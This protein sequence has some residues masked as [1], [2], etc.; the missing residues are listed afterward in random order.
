MTTFASPANSFIQFRSVDD[1]T[2]LTTCSD[3]MP[4]CL[5]V[6]FNTDLMFQLTMEL[7]E[8]ESLSSFYVGIVQG[9]EDDSEPLTI[10]YYGNL[11]SGFTEAVTDEA[12]IVWATGALDIAEYDLSG[13]GLEH[14]D[15]FRLG[16]FKDVVTYNYTLSESPSGG[17]YAVYLFIDGV[18]TQIANGATLANTAALVTL[19]N[20]YFDEQDISDVATSPAPGVIVIISNSGIVYGAM[21]FTGVPAITV[22]LVT[23]TATTLKYCSNCFK[24]IEETC[25]TSVLKYLCNENSFGFNYEDATY[26]NLIRL[27]LYLDNPQPKTTRNTFRLSD[28]TY[29]KLSSVIEKEP[30]G[31]VGYMDEDQHFK[32][33]MLLEHDHVYVKAATESTFQKIITDEA[34]YEIGWLNKPGTNINAAPASFKAKVDPYFQVN[35]NCE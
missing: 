15:C 13:F 5:P 6:H 2:E 12:A 31:N 28:G 25:Y 32:M 3:V 29:K 23:N 30:Q 21:S 19:L 14:D 7:D 35:S 4:T 11:F 24:Y 9:C 34:N 16:I 17:V 22:E 1:E 27:P 33:T 8:D 18:D 26:Y 10:A 20:T